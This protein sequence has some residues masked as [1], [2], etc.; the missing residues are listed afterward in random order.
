LVC[1]QIPA[2]PPI[3]EDGVWIGIY[4]DNTTA[5]RDD[6]VGKDRGK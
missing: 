6:L 3:L 2:S 4:L 5:W 1:S